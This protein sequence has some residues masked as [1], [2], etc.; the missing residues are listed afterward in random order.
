MPDGKDSNNILAQ[1]P[2]LELIKPYPSSG[3]EI[4]DLKLEDIPKD[5]N[6]S[7][8]FSSQEELELFQKFCKAGLVGDFPL[9]QH[10]IDMIKNYALGKKLYN[11]NWD[12]FR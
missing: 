4:T 8:Y 3:K 6:G 9:Y 1:E 10:Q 11:Y 7:N 5:S 12:R 2:Y